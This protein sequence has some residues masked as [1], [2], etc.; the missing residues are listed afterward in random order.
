M[1]FLHDKTLN[2]FC[3]NLHKEGSILAAFV[4]LVAANCFDIIDC[5]IACYFLKVETFTEI[6]SI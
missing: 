6:M 5:A 3:L 4:L 1:C 2:T